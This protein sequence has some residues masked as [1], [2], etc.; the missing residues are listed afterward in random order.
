MLGIVAALALLTAQEQSP[1][2][3]ILISPSGTLT[4]LSRSQ[5]IAE[6]GDRLDQDTDLRLAPMDPDRADG[7]RG[8]L[9]CL[10]ELARPDY[11]R[12]V[13]ERANGTM[14]EFQA[15]LDYIERKGLD[16][17]EL[18][19]V[20]SGVGAAGIDVVSIDLIDTTE[21]LEYLHPI[22]RL[23]RADERGLLG[24]AR[25]GATFQAEVE[26]A[27][28][29]D[30]M[31]DSLFA[32]L[33]QPALEARAHWR[34]YGALV[35]RAPE[36][37]SAFVDGS[38][39]ATAGSEGAARARV[40]PGQREV[41][42]QHPDFAPFSA[43]VQVERGGQSTVVMELRR[44]GANPDFGRQLTQWTGVALAAAGTGLLIAGAVDAG[45]NPLTL[46]CASCDGGFRF[47]GFSNS[48]GT[49]A[50]DPL[51]TS[52]PLVVPLGYSL[53]L[54]GATWSIGA[55]LS[56]KERTPWWVLL[57]GAAAGGTAYA[58]SAAA[59]GP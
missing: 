52:G 47:R 46:T 51:N 39:V 20:I 21:A 6:L 53:A 14:A 58:I 16:P 10:V 45:Q 4:H 24:A 41:T 3:F 18:L 12:A 29:L 9:S 2:A 33:L 13:Y 17:P 30:P 43:S 40:L 55:A 22:E 1:L 48:P 25:V 54:T 26:S 31:L 5:V 7:C 50:S 8:R 57:A 11:Q 49:S 15:H 32:D 28:E 34:P 19:L 37:A 36:G 27:A 38:L 59:Q 56:E 44:P 42:V 35:V 23:T